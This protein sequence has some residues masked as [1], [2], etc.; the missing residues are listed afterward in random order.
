MRM[1]KFLRS[2]VLVLALLLCCL[3]ATAGEVGTTRSL[4]I[5]TVTV[6][7]GS[8]AE[9]ALRELSAKYKIHELGDGDLVVIDEAG[10]GVIGGVKV[11]AGKVVRVSCDWG[12]RGASEAHALAESLWAVLAEVTN[13]AEASARIVTK[14]IRKPNDTYYDI[15][16]IF[17]DRR[18]SLTSSKNGMLGLSETIEEPILSKSQ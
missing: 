4:S 18:V 13:D 10:A 1:G 9:S 6:V 14:S 5:G 15:Q 11:R 3:P 16:I 17:P 7:L 12:N 2:Q 8:P